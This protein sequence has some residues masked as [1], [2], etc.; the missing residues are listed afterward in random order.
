MI[1]ALQAKHRWEALFA[2][3]PTPRT[4]PTAIPGTSYA[5]RFVRQQGLLLLRSR[6]PSEVRASTDYR[7]AA[8]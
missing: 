7:T 3:S 1:R 5:S 8:S 6:R 2:A 4:P